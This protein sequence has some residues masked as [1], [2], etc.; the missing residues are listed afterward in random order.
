MAT[1]NL[2]DVVKAAA[3]ANVEKANGIDAAFNQVLK[4]A[5][6]SSSELSDLWMEYGYLIDERT[7]GPYNHVPVRLPRRRNSAPATSKGKGPQQKKD[8]KVVEDP[9]LFKV[10]SCEHSFSRSQFYQDR[11]FQSALRRYY[12]GLGRSISLISTKSG[13]LMKIYMD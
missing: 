6:L 12:R 8:N 7:G 11:D 1:N 13:W 3:A 9:D 5:Q 2:V 10:A 4:E